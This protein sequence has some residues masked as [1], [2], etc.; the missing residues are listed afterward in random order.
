MFG[1]HTFVLRSIIFSSQ[2]KLVTS[3]GMDFFFN[4]CIDHKYLSFQRILRGAR[5]FLRLKANLHLRVHDVKSC[6]LFYIHKLKLVNK[7]RR[8]IQ[9]RSKFEFPT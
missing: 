5:P 3:N 6:K 9:N 2:L 1:G 8:E 7:S 4:F